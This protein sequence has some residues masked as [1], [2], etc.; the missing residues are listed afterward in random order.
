MNEDPD[1]KKQVGKSRNLARDIRRNFKEL[2][3]RVLHRRP[4][5]TRDVADLVDAIFKEIWGSDLSADERGRLLFAFGPWDDLKMAVLDARCQ[6]LPEDTIPTTRAD[7]LKLCESLLDRTNDL[8]MSTHFVAGWNDVP[9]TREAAELERFS[10]LLWNTQANDP[11]FFHAVVSGRHG[12]AVTYLVRRRIPHGLS[13]E[14]AV[15]LIYRMALIWCAHDVQATAARARRSTIGAFGWLHFDNADAKRMVAGTPIA[16]WRAVYEML[17]GNDGQYRTN[18]E[19]R[20]GKPE[21]KPTR[22]WDVQTIKKD[23]RA[24]LDLVVPRDTTRASRDA[25]VTGVRAAATDQ[26]GIFWEEMRKEKTSPQL[27]RQQ[28][29]QVWYHGLTPL[30][31]TALGVIRLIQMEAI[32]EQ[33]IL[34]IYK[35][36]TG[37][38]QLDPPLLP[39]QEKDLPNGWETRAQL[40]M[41]DLRRTIVK[42]VDLGSQ[43]EDRKV[44]DGEP[45]HD[46]TCLDEAIEFIKQVAVP[47][48]D[49]EPPTGP[50]RT[51]ALLNVCVPNRLR[52]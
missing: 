32:L 42:D 10:D 43:N 44:G 40:L 35:F 41:D 50:R 29:S 8:R 22:H 45:L 34:G 12:T 17:I 33:S 2:T 23:V 15:R 20:A 3:K 37:G 28:M 47:A 30:Q 36:P 27:A 25:C 11:E 21:A 1:D 5:S 7:L 18:E 38:A 48:N 19:S 9:A 14:A 26:K 39:F 46:D 52:R 16:V 31:V 13:A 24:W 51:Y 49:P 4:N 6:P